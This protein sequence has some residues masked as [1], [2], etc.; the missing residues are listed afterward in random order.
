MIYCLIRSCDPTGIKCYITSMGQ[1]IQYVFGATLPRQITMVRD[2]DTEF[3]VLGSNAIIFQKGL[4]YY[5]SESQHQQ[6]N[7]SA[8]EHRRVNE[9]VVGLLHVD[10]DCLS[11]HDSTNHSIRHMTV[12]NPCSPR[13]YRRFLKFPNFTQTQ[14][15]YFPQTNSWWKMETAHELFE[16]WSLLP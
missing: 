6:P 15:L 9:N 16:G 14:D 4:I 8:A 7:T 10:A 1:K 5:T 2:I 3:N 12:D 11:D 13:V